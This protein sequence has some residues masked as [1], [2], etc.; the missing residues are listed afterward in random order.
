MFK[1]WFEYHFVPEV[2]RFQTGVLNIPREEV[3]PLLI[4]DN[5]P[6]HPRVAELREISEHIRVMYMPANCTSVIQPMDQG[7]IASGKR[8]YRRRFL[9][10]TLEV[11][12]EE[13]DVD[14][15]T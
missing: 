3:K 11:L 4:L 14:H 10:E 1:E 13:D 2:I 6:S 7:I 12:E 8:F 15:D 9:Q 5:A